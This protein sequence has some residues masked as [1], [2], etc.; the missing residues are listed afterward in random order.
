MESTT[1]FD[2]LLLRMD[3]NWEEDGSPP[4]L[5]VPYHMIIENEWNEGDLLRFIKQEDG[6]WSIANLSATDT[7][8]EEL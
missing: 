3:L 7:W 8:P 1:K 4:Y 6:S 5:A 2:A